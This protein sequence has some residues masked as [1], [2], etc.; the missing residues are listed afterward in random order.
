MSLLLGLALLAALVVW[1]S[2]PS[3]K[4]EPGDAIHPVDHDALVDAEKEMEGGTGGALPEG[5]AEEDWGPGAP[6]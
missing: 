1:L 6:R 3:E 2:R 5:A 4:V